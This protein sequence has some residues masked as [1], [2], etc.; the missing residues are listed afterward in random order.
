MMMSIIHTKT[1]KGVVKSLGN[2]R[3]RWVQR[4]NSI[5]PIVGLQG[6]EEEEDHT[7]KMSKKKRK[8]EEKMTT[9][10]GGNGV[11]KF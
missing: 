4:P 11:G 8:V 1:C 10:E 5:P 7:K 3:G 2:I 9:K 6:E